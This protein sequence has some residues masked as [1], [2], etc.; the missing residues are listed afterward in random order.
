MSDTPRTVRLGTRGSALA[1]WQTNQV[2]DLLQHAWPELDVSVEVIATHGDRALDAPLALIGGKGVFTAE[3][4]MALRERAI[5]FA[6]HSLKDLPTEPSPGLVIGAIP[7]RANAQD[8]LISKAG[9]T[10]E[11]LPRGATIGTSSR[12]RAAQLL[13]RR[14]D[15]RITDLRGNVDTRIR[16]ALDPTGVYDAV[17]LAL[18]GVERLGQQHAVSETLPVETLLP[19]PGQGALAVQCRD[20]P[21]AR[22]LLA[23]LA[24]KEVE[25]PVTAERAFL[26][27]LGGGCAVPV[28]AYAW[29]DG[30]ALRLRG[31]I[32]APD[33][34]EQVDVATDGAISMKAAIRLGRRAARVALEQGAKRLLAVSP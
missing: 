9:Y 28:A 18:A 22:A 33:G 12:R 21:A 26:A 5:D 11:T 4:E 3:L 10:L 19:A 15:L 23:P 27:A 34:S 25:V 2:R 31:R 7:A 24:Q 1:R 30:K 8:V 20:E 14:P 17:V 32:T 13:H 16:K 29:I 6:V